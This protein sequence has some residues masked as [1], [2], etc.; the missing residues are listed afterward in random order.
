MR[1]IAILATLL[2]SLVASGIEYLPDSKAFSATSLAVSQD[3]ERLVSGY[4]DNTIKVWSLL[5][6]RLIHNLSFNSAWVTSV[7]VSL[8]GKM[9]IAGYDDG[10]IIVWD[11][12]TGKKIKSLS[13]HTS[14]VNDLVVTE[15]GKTLYSCSSDATVKIWSLSSLSFIRTLRG[16]SGSVH[17]I[18]DWPEQNRLYSA[19]EDGTLRIWDTS[20]GQQVKVIRAEIGSLT[21]VSMDK[22]RTVLIIGSEAGHLRSYD[23]KTWSPLKTSRVH[24]AELTKILIN[25]GLIFTASS[26]RTIKSL[27][28]PSFTLVHMITGHNWDVTE[29]VLSNDGHVLYSSSTDGTL[30][31]WDIEKASPIGTLIGFGDGEYFSYN[32]NGNWVSSALAPERVTTEDGASPAEV[33][34]ELSSLLLQLD[35]LPKI[36]T[37]A[38]LSISIERDTVDFSVSKPVKKVTVN[39]EEV[40]IGEYGEVVFRPD[41]TGDYIIRAYDDSGS[42]DERTVTVQ[43]EETVMY[44]VREISTYKRGDRV[45][46]DDF[47]ELE[48][49]V[50]GE[51]LDRDSFSRVVPDVEPPLITGDKVQKVSIGDT[52]YLKLSVSDNSTVTL[53]EIVSPDLT[54]TPLAVNSVSTEIR[55]EVQ[56][57]GEY[58][59]NAYD[60]DGN[61]AMSTFSLEAEA[62]S[63]WV[64]IDHESLRLG[65]EVKV[66]EEGESCY[67]VSDYG[68]LEK[69]Y[70]SKKPISTGDPIISGEPVQQAVSGTERILSFTVSDDV[71]VK[72]VVVSGKTYP[73][74]EREKEMHIMVSEYGEHLVIVNDVEG[75]SARASFTLSAPPEDERA[76]GKIWHWL[77][78]IV[79]ILPLVLLLTTK[80]SKKKTRKIRL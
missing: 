59:V 2:F 4:I 14:S 45:I 30:K 49:L 66:T 23:V 72:E 79:I 41:G 61:K 64:S 56:G 18:V 3:G 5:D 22:E 9:G 26:D 16:H 27:S 21:A 52:K 12:L 11:L 7:A 39:E 34:K 10:I 40:D 67:F 37:P 35:K 63:F 20:S 24:N 6:G 44:V 76:G 80:S 51:W 75:N 77:I 31:I 55:T 36:Y 71:N 25:D 13:S 1:R 48:F 53:I 29:I 43:F 46:I 62:R 33:A 32:S 15:D 42:F 47:R 60:Q 28:F 65:Q 17:S 57:T 19:S 78:P 70:L 38:I 50:N 58:T 69:E 73:V 54:V 74:N 8:D 68:W